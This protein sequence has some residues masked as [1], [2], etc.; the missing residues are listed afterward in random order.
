MSGRPDH[1]PWRVALVLDGDRPVDGWPELLAA[2]ALVVVAD[3]GARHARQAGVRVDHLVGDLDSLSDAEVAQVHEAGATV[4]RHPTDKDETD[5]ELAA[6]LAVALASDRPDEEPRVLVVGGSGGRH[7]HLVGNL[8]VLAGPRFA[9]TAVTALMGTAV[10]Q[11]AR[12]DRPV[13]LYGGV[14]SL[15]SLYPVGI[16]AAGVTTAGLGYPLRDDTLSP[17]SARGTSN[18]VR[19]APASVR[20]A[21][22]L[23]LVIEPDAIASLIPPP[24]ETP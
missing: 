16:P 18:V 8:V 20:L 14:D 10:V 15:A 3:G 9:T 17:G 2:D 24:K 11:V 13:A 19:Q 4:H 12:P 21:T 23:L 6:D 5:F 22:G 1:A 7:D